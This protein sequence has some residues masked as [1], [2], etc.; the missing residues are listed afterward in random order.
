MI[1]KSFLKVLDF[2]LYSSTQIALSATLFIFQTYLLLDIDIDYHYLIFIFSSTLFLYVLH[3]FLGVYTPQEEVIQDKLIT[4]RKMRKSLLVMFV[5]SG[6]FSVYSFFKLSIDEII[7][8]VFFAFISIWYVIP[9]F[10]QRLRDYPIIKI[11]MVALV[12]AAI[13]TLIPFYNSDV[14][15]LTR[16]LIFLEKYFF[17]FAITI[18]FDI[19]DIEFDCA[20]KVKTI[21]NKYG[22]KKSIILAVFALIVSTSIASF[23]IE[24]DIYKPVQGFAVILGY[25]VTG[26]VVVLSKDIK[27]DYYFTGLIDGLPIFNFLI[28]FLA[29]II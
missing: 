5:I 20:K 25:L 14:D 19:R 29:T 10:G 9:L 21:P 11:F 27:S 7:A 17:I 15:I 24:S 1:K 22:I 3:N 2:Y 26:I 13:A 28:V 23:L 4:L 18:P 8:L 16:T 6:V 12:W